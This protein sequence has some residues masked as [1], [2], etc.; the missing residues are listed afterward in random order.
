MTFPFDYWYRIQMFHVGPFKLRT[1]NLMIQR[2]FKQNGDG[3]WLY[4]LVKFSSL[5][6]F[7]CLGPAENYHLN[8][9]RLVPYSVRT[10]TV[11]NFLR[12]N[13]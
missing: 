8:S 9:T 13:G 4:C 7:K 5:S 12:P 10:P 1:G 11:L 6:V 3:N 2:L